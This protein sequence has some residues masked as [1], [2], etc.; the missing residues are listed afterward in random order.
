[1]DNNHSNTFFYQDK[2]L[3]FIDESMT[4]LAISYYPMLD[5]DTS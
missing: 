1:M 2:S 5:R 3:G 4:P